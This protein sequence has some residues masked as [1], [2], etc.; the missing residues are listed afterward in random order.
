MPSQETTNNLE[1][2]E[3]EQK[4]EE[5]SLE[6]VLL[7]FRTTRPGTFSYDPSRIDDKNVNQMRFEIGDTY[8]GY[9]ANCSVLSDEEYAVLISNAKDWKSAKIAI[10]KKILWIFAYEV[11]YTIDGLSLKLSDRFNRFKKILDDLLAE[12]TLPSVDDSLLR[13]GRGGHYF[14]YGMLEN[15]RKF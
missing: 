5:K 12:D 1:E 6:D 14:H 3:T 2:Q 4:N 8:T 13:A 7:D 15:Y 11:D 10:L 9:S